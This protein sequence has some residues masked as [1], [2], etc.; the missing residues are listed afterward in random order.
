MKKITSI[1]LAAILY[2]CGS[3]VSPVDQGSVVE[4]KSVVGAVWLALPTF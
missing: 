2:S 4:G 1:F 3:S